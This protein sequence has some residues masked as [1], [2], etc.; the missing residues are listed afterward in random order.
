MCSFTDLG[1][2]TKPKLPVAE[3]LTSSPRQTHS[4]PLFLR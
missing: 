2:M 1:M 4:N 3:K